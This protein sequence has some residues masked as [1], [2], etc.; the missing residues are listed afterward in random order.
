MMGTLAVGFADC[1]N[2]ERATL[3][4][5][6]MLTSREVCAAELQQG[7]A[8]PAGSLPVAQAHGDAS[9]QW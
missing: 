3:V 5:E 9:L 2:T 4:L 1:T 6:A 7:I 8:C